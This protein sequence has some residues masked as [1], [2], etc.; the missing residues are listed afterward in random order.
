MVDGEVT[1]I[2][3]GIEVTGPAAI[4]ANGVYPPPFGTGSTLT[5]DITGARG[6]TAS[7]SRTSH[8]SSGQRSETF[9]IEP[10]ARRRRST[11]GQG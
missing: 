6:R 2:P 9:R 4:T 7:R 5:I 10:S 8:C 1:L 11:F 3:N